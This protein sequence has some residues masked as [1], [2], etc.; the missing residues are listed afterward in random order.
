MAFPS[1]DAEAIRQCREQHRD[2]FTA[3]QVNNPALAVPMD[4]PLQ[5]LSSM[6][7]KQAEQRLRAIAGAEGS[8]LVDRDTA[9]LVDSSV[10]LD[11]NEG[12][13]LAEGG[14][15]PLDERR[16]ERMVEDVAEGAERDRARDEVL[17][18]CETLDDAGLDGPTVLENLAEGRETQAREL[19]RGTDV[20][21]GLEAIEATLE[22][23]RVEFG[24][25]FLEGAIE[26]CR[27]RLGGPDD[28]DVTPTQELVDEIRER[29]GVEALTLDRALEELQSEV[30]QADRRTEEAIINRLERGF[31]QQFDSIDDAIDRLRERIAA[32]RGERLRLADVEV[33]RVGDEVRV[34]IDTSELAQE[35]EQLFRPWE[36]NVE[37]RVR[38]ELD[39]TQLPNPSTWVTVG[40][41]GVRGEDLDMIDL[42]EGRERLGAVAEPQPLEAERVERE[43]AELPAAETDADELADR[44][45]EL[46]EG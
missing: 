25:T 27:D 1:T 28:G 40:E 15:L 12:I 42:Q 5:C 3:E 44:A 39:V 6:Q 45:L 26:A 43:Q 24:G 21:G 7:Q 8:A 33:R 11:A 19:L 32:A 14:R 16:R 29:F 46:L 10:S 2:L 31:G 34:R 22:G 18:V 35:D 4:A 17:T 37:R 38:R 36:D 9:S 23:I 20:A 41:I 30:R 13:L